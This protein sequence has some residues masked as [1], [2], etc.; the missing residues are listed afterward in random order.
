MSE[1]KLRRDLL[2]LLVEIRAGSVYGDPVSRSKFMVTS[3][4]GLKVT[5]QVEELM[6]HELACKGEV[7]GGT[8]P[9]ELTPAG[10]LLLDTYRGAS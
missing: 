10:V 7:V 5:P 2:A 3:A 9:V 8:Y 4:G 1:L 6:A